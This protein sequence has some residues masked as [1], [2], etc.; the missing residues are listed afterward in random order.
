MEERIFI[1]VL[2]NLA[3]FLYRSG[4]L[5]E[6]A[7][8][9]KYVVPCYQPGR[10]HLP[11]KAIMLLVPAQRHRQ[12]LKKMALQQCFFFFVFIALFWQ[13]TRSN[14][15]EITQMGMTCQSS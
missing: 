13:F 7:K 2:E 14:V 5:L 8:L 10:F 1:K 4:W 6:Q 9:E 3:P 15:C 12:A 11:K